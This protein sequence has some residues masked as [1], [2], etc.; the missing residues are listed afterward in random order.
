MW[1]KEITDTLKQTALV[2][3]FLLLIPLIF[4]VNQMR[5][6]EADLNFMWYFDWSLSYLIPVFIIYLAY[7]IFAS[8]DSD[9]ATEYLRTL[10]VNKWKLLT[11]KILPRFFVCTVLVLIYEALFQDSSAHLAEFGWFHYQRT[12]LYPLFRTLFILIPMIYGYM[13]G[14]SD[15]K[16]LILPIAFAMPLL[17]MISCRNLFF[18]PFTHAFYDLFWPH[19]QQTNIKVFF[20]LN[21]LIQLYIPVLLPIAVLIPVFKSWDCSSG[22]LRSQRILKRI[23]APLGLLIL[24]YTLSQFNL[25]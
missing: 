21:S 24:L 8:E 1:K 22:K 11:A 16:N 7:N 3:S 25:F 9:S 5:F 13:L 19:F 15:R 17:Y 20:A 6:Q 4:A 12:R 2:L 23:A 10:P 18:T 14:I